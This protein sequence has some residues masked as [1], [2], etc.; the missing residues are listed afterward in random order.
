MIDQNF[1]HLTLSVKAK[2]TRF[3]IRQ[4]P[5]KFGSLESDMDQSWDKILD[6][7]HCYKLLL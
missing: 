7:K 5:H 1:K 2:P 3:R 6:P 4:D